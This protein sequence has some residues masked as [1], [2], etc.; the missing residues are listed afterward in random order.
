M[1]RKYFIGQDYNTIK[2]KDDI[3]ETYDELKKSKLVFL[4]DMYDNEN[5]LKNL[6]SIYIRHIHDTEER[7]MKDVMFFNDIEVDEIL[8]NRFRYAKRTKTNIIQFI[9]IYKR[10]GVDR[11]DIS[12]NS[13]DAIDRKVATKDLPKV[14]INKVWG[15]G[16]FYNLL[17]NA[18]TKSDISNAMPLLLARYGILGKELI[19]MRSLR[20]EDIDYENKQVKIIQHGQVTRIID[21]DERFIEWID[22]YKLSF[23]DETTDYGY[24]LKKN[25]KAKDDSLLDSNATIHSRVYRLCRELEIP[26]IA[27]G[28]LLKSRYLDLLLDIRKDRKLTTDDFTWVILN[29]KDKISQSNTQVLKEYYE[30]LTKD[31]VINKMDGVG[32]KGAPKDSLK[33]INSKARAEE[34]RKNIHFEEYINGEENYTKINVN[35]ADEV[36]ATMQEVATT[37]KE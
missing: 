19:E 25:D 11:G 10:W 5:T 17:S 18:Q 29:F 37:A 12:G 9:N 16:R 2:E 20:W 31:T 4:N 30:T 26:R 6:W 1:K 7:K 21:V 13:V 35:S 28:D 14:L 24:V 36:T 23:N 15:L 27:M 32:S 22:K 3:L 34:I 8:A 33:E